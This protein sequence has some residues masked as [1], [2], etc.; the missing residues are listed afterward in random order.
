MKNIIKYIKKK[1]NLNT[2][3]YEMFK[4][5]AYHGNLS[6]K[7]VLLENEDIISKFTIYTDH[8]SNVIREKKKKGLIQYNRLQYDNRTGYYIDGRKIDTKIHPLHGKTLVNIL[9][10]IKYTIDIVSHNNY[11]G[12][13]ISLLVRAHG[14]KSHKEVIWQDVSCHYEPFLREIEINNNKYELIDFI[15]EPEIK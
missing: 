11:Y 9:N 14:S 3:F 5:N 7:Y 1:L 12:E 13:Y 10:D 15:K 2:K 4:Y 6:P 8:L